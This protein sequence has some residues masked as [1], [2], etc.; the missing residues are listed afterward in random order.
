MSDTF[1][2]AGDAGSTGPAG[3]EL[4]SG[5]RTDDQAAAWVDTVENR[6]LDRVEAWM[7][8]ELED[9]VLRIVEAKLREETERR[10]WRRGLGVF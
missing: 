7:S 3:A 5:P 8:V 10:A 6:V 2:A 1:G 9:R 4:G